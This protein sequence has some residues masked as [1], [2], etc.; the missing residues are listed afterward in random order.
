M[1]IC[2][3]VR[4]YLQMYLYMHICTYAYVYIYIYGLQLSTPL[5]PDRSQDRSKAFP[6]EA[7]P[8]NGIYDGVTAS[9]GSEGTTT[10]RVVSS[11]TIMV[12]EVKS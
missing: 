9:D 7:H 11:R 1:H 12:S 4:M 10:G 2:M 6:W 8:K 3:H 5:S